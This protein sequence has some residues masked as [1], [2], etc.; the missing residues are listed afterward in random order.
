MKFASLG[1][2][3]GDFGGKAPFGQLMVRLHLNESDSWT[4]AGLVGNFF[5]CL[6]FLWLRRGKRIDGWWDTQVREIWRCRL[7]S[8]SAEPN[9]YALAYSGELVG[10]FYSEVRICFVLWNPLHGWCWW[11]RFSIRWLMWRIGEIYCSGNKSWKPDGFKVSGSF[12]C[13]TISLSVYA[14]W[15][16]AIWLLFIRSYAWCFAW[17]WFWMSQFFFFWDQFQSRQSLTCFKRTF[18]F[19][20]RVVWHS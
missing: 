12:Y 20:I 17:T 18:H 1:R 14:P 6:G 9:L 4:C 10:P 19:S 15:L 16:F 8:V 2:I 5:F 7:R 3:L 11:V 13:V